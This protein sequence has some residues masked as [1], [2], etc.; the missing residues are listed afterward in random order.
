MLT[1][2]DDTPARAQP[3]KRSSYKVK[4][5]EN[6]HAIVISTSLPSFQIA[7]HSITVSELLLLRTQIVLLFRRHRF[8]DKYSQDV[9]CLRD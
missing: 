8:R 2:E 7:S 4:G 9:H 5:K 3:S 1:C 6:M